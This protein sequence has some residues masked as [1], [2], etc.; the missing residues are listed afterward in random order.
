MNILEF[1][2]GITC[3]KSCLL[4]SSCVKNNVKLLD[5]ES[6]YPPQSSS[7]QCRDVDY[8]F[9]LVIYDKEFDS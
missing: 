1:G 8:Q 9:S 6:V 5:G 4:Q 2:D 7:S 3:H